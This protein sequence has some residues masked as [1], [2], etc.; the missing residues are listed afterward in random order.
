MAKIVRITTVPVSMQKLLEGQLNF[1]SQFYEMRA[2]S[3]DGAEIEAIEKEEGVKVHRINLTREITPF[4]DLLAII[5]LYRFLRR[6]KPEII[7]S[8]TPKAGLVGMVA[9][10]FAGVKIRMHTVAGLPLMEASGTKLWV[11]RMVEKIVYQFATRIYPNSLELKK[12]IEQEG[13]ARTEKLKV[14]GAGSSNGINLNR[15]KSSESIKE[16]ARELQEQYQFNPAHFVY[17]FIGRVVIDKGI[18]E[19]ITSFNSIS[20]Q[21]RN[22]RLLLVGDHEEVLPKNLM[23]EIRSNSAIISVGFQYDVR[24]YLELADVF[25][26]PSYREGFP[27]VVLQAGC[28]NLPCIVTNINGSNE[29]IS[30]GVNGLIIEKKDAVALEISMRRL[31]NDRVLARQMGELAR[32]NI[33]QKYDQQVVWQLIKEEYELQLRNYVR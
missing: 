20:D 30:D 32:K 17:C 11:L 28:F 23:H 3:S 12:Y 6:E 14:I 10:Y 27:N 13:L 24:P 2:V 16:K 21:N 22:A 4:K 15:F 1:M 19:L 9:A 8:H 29:I 25:V 18:Q 7:H 5:A 26:F 33:E 31:L